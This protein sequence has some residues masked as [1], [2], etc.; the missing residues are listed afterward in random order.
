[1]SEQRTAMALQPQACICEFRT[2]IGLWS[3]QGQLHP[4]WKM[5]RPAHDDNGRASSLLWLCLG[6]PHTTQK[7][8]SYKTQPRWSCPL[9]SFLE[10]G[11]IS[12]SLGSLLWHL[13]PPHPL[14]WPV[15]TNKVPTLC[16]PWH[17]KFNM[18][19][20]PTPAP[21][22]CYHHVTEKTLK[23]LEHARINKA[24][25]NEELW[26]FPHWKNYF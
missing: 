15:S 23:Y 20:D 10:A 6:H 22:E 24:M 1:M 17:W 18:R 11:P 2:F 13:N 3:A 8:Y 21:K 14:L 4:L 25:W 19:A 7:V 5:E 12:T 26:K 16:Q 9:G